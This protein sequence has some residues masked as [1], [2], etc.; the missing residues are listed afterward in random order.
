[1]KNN[2]IK[3]NKKVVEKS[4]KRVAV[5]VIERQAQIQPQ[6]INISLL[7][8]KPID[9]IATEIRKNLYQLGLSL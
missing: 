5:F 6:T 2:I 4:E 7:S 8:V 9:E 3:G 1:M